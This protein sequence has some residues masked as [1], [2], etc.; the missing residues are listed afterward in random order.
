MKWLDA[1]RLSETE[2]RG[3]TFLS[4]LLMLAVLVRLFVL[5]VPD[6]PINHK[7]DAQ[8]YEE[9]LSE[10]EEKMRVPHAFNPNTITDTA[11]YEIGL[12]PYVVKNWIALR[13]RGNTFYQAEDVLKI[14]GMDT[15]WFEINRDS[16]IIPNSKKS[17]SIPE[18]KQP[19]YFAF[20]PNV[21]TVYQMQQLGFPDW[22]ATR[23][24]K[25]R[26]KGGRFKTAADLQKI[27]GFPSELFDKVEKYIQIETQELEPEKPKEAV[28]LSI[29]LNTADTTELMAVNGIGRTFAKRILAYRAKLG[30]FYSVS[31]LTEVYGLSADKLEAFNADFQ[32][33]KNQIQ[34]LNLNQ[35][36]FKELVAHPYLE[37]EQ[38]KQIVNYREA[39]GKFDDVG[40]LIKLQH[41]TQK[42]LERLKY[43]LQVE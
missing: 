38:V 29:N 26:Q 2:K 37:Y 42:D 18:Y 7:F 9:W 5:F 32:I 41:F 23:I 40:Q 17:K 15:A 36:T 22:L 21:V 30:G 11:L 34:Q 16:L 10:R 1:F 4:I 28:R 13:K 24:E 25:F 43:Y 14:Y 31:Q 8:A 39:L 19:V 27:Y 12:Q 6:R 33:D 35:A 3:F 20:D